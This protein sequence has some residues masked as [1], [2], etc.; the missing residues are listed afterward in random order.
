MAKKL[1]PGPI[2]RDL[3]DMAIVPESFTDLKD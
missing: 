1:T 3:D 2:F